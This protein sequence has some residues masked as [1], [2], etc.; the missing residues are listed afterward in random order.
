MIII[1][2]DRCKSN[3]QSLPTRVKTEILEKRDLESVLQKRT[4]VINKTANVLCDNCLYNLE[5]EIISFETN[6]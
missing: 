4:I 1:S 2:C 5:L 3:I 6:Q